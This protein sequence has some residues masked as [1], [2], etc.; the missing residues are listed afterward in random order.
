MLIG[1]GESWRVSFI[2]E[3]DMVTANTRA[4]RAREAALKSF[5][6]DF[7]NVIENRI[8]INAQPLFSLLA[9]IKFFLRR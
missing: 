6:K 7:E 9:I 4:E 1:Q 3:P 8:F 2:L 5:V